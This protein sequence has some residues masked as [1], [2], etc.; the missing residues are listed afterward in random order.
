MATIYFYTPPSSPCRKTIPACTNFIIRK[1]F[2]QC[3]FLD[4]FRLSPFTYTPS[5]AQ[6]GGNLPSLESSHFISLKVRL[7]VHTKAP[8]QKTKPTAIPLV[9][10]H[11]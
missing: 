7:Q 11:E 3:G 9:G 1:Q 6:G 8:K 5:S 2:K 4:V 10:E